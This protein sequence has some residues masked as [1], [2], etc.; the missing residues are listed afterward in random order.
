M[1]ARTGVEA[2]SGLAH[3][4]T[5]TPANVDDVMEV[6]RL[7]QGK[8]YV[9]R[10]QGQTVYVDAGYQGAEKLA[11][12]RGRRWHIAVKRGSVKTMPEDEWKDVTGGRHA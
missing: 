12:E 5:T 6:D 2:E 7:L 3:T 10:W 4:V 1:K 8:G 9:S 11:P